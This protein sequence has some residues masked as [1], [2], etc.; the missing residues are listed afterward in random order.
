MSMHVT[1]KCHCGAVSFSAEVEKDKVIVCHCTDCQVMASSAFRVGALVLRESFSIRGQVSEYR[2]IGTSGN[3]RSLVFCPVCATSIY[4]YMKNDPG[5]Y[6]SLR[7][8][9]IDQFKE[10]IPVHQIWQQSALP[11]LAQLPLIPCSM[12][13]E[14][15]AA[16][17][18]PSQAP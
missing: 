18:S 2:K 12:Q 11:W 8:G 13:Q 3:E 10:L 5:P 7:L 16:A 9:G 14:A 6:L 15:I 4:S 17:I 1:G